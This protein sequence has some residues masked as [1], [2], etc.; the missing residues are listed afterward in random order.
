MEL[1]AEKGFAATSTRELSE[2]L[3]FTKAALYYHFRTKEDLLFALVEPGMQE[4]R[5]L[6]DGMTSTGR[7]DRQELLDGYVTIVVSNLD[8]FRLV[9]REPAVSSIERLAN[10]SRP[11]YEELI[12]RLTG[13]EQP[14]VSDVA[15]AHVA[16]GG[17][18]A[19]FLNHAPDADIGDVRRGAFAG[20]CGALGL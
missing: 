15:R 18:H 16:L 14:D 17:I 2:R 20:A 9:S 8:L 4:F 19:A 1:I 6:L 13:L 10:L 7:S 5:E 3:G 11:L 12:T